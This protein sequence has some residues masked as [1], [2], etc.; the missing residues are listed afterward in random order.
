MTI[1]A[2]TGDAVAGPGP[3]KRLSA[4]HPYTAWFPWALGT[5]LAAILALRLVDL[6]RLPGELYGDIAIIYEYVLAIRKGQWPTHYV[7]SAGPLYQYMIVP[8][9]WLTGLTYYGLKLASVLVSLATLLAIFALGRELIDARFGLLA[10]FVAGVSSWLLIFSRLG[11]SQIL[12]PLLCTSAVYF[13]VR[14][15]QYGRSG[16]ALGCGLVSGLGLFCL[17]QTFILPPVL[18]LTLLCL[19]WTGTRV[20]WTHLLLFAV[21]TLVCALPFAAI[22]ARDP[23]NFFTGYIGGKLVG[24]RGNVLRTLLGNIAR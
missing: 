4:V 9:V 6:D 11:N 24:A 16:D 13:A 22:V 5:T 10:T 14:L 23:A 19:R 15:A 20:R 3:E 18:F 17:P 1:Q 2:Q 12:V 21:A 7:L 8:V